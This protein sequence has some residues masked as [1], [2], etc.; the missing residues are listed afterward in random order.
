L[1]VDAFI[2][3]GQVWFTWSTTAKLTGAYEEDSAI[4]FTLTEE[5][6]GWTFK[7]YD[8]HWP[9]NYLFVSGN[10]GQGGLSA[11]SESVGYAMHVDN[12]TDVHRYFELVKQESGYYR[13]RIAANDEVYGETAVTNWENKYLGWNPNEES[14]P[15][16]LHASVTAENGYE[17]DF[18]FFDTYLQIYDI[19]TKLY[20]LAETIVLED[21]DVDYGQFTSVY[22][23]N[24]YDAL[25]NAYEQLNNLIQAARVNRFLHFGVDGVNPPSDSNPADGTPL[26]ENYDFTGCSN[27]NFPGWTIY[28]PNG[29]NTWVHG[30]TAVEYWNAN[31][32]SGQFD[33]YQVLKGL[34]AGKYTLTASMWNSMNGVSGTFEATSGVYGTTSFGTQAALVEDDCDD[35]NLHEYTTLAIILGE[36]DDLRIGVKNVKTMVAR[37]FGVDYIHLTYYG[38][39]TS[40]PVSGIQLNESTVT[41][42]KGLTHQLTATVL[43]SDASNTNVIWSSTDETV[44]TVDENGLVTAVGKGTAMIIALTEEGYKSAMCTVTVDNVVTSVT[45]NNEALTIAKNGTAQLTATCTP[46][47]ADDLSLTWASSDETVATV[48]ATGQVTA[49]GKGTATITVTAATGVSAQCVVTVTNPMTSFRFANATLTLQK[50]SSQAL[51]LVPTPADADPVTLVWSSTDETVAT[52]DENGV[53]TAIDLG[54]TVIVAYSPDINKSATCVVTVTKKNITL[55]DG[56]PYANDTE[57]ECGTITYTRT[58]NNTNFQALYVPFEMSYAD[59]QADFEVYY[60]DNI[61]Q[62]DDNGDGVIDRTMRWISSC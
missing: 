48:D 34:P 37:W 17:L 45:L 15:N 5:E 13:I 6:N 3:G 25:V 53:L 16:N 52:V 4:G 47:D 36:G 19:K 62:H 57:E 59:W 55:A 29:G 27:G 32:A 26:I 60:I 46:A 33:Y 31:A 20:S 41:I 23:G 7:G 30:E 12:A 1:N 50:G 54:T 35:S 38:K 2:G 21:M 9:N 22:N 39:I 40:S 11:D 24:D 8:G 58:F 43:P 51:T 10:N 28:A 18:E 61:R 56:T 14:Y 42:H 49:I 44:A